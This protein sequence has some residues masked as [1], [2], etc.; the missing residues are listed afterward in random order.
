MRLRNNVNTSIH[1][2]LGK[3]RVLAPSCGIKLQRV[4][5][6]VSDREREGGIA[7]ERERERER[8]RKRLGEQEMRVSKSK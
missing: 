6:L 7:S 5:G 2:W 4:R 3:R 1:S 8:V